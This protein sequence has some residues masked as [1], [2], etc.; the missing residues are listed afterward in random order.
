MHCMH[1]PDQILTRVPSMNQVT[2]L[3]TCTHCLM[4]F[5]DV[6]V[7]KYMKKVTVLKSN[8]LLSMNV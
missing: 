7:V 1:I 6:A 3:Q 2:C 4:M 8:L 5:D